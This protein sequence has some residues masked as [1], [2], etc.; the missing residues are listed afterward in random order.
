MNFNTFLLRLGFDPENFVNKES[1]PIRIYNGYI[2]EAEQR[3]DDRRCPR[4]GC[5][6]TEIH[7]HYYTETR[8]SELEYFTDILRIKRVRFR[9]PVC[10]KT[11]SPKIKGIGTKCKVSQ[12]AKAFIRND[13]TTPIT[14]DAIGGKYGVSTSYIIKMFDEEFK[15]IP[16]KPL[17]K[18]LCIDEIKFSTSNSKYCCILYDFFNKDIVDIIESRQL[19]YLKQYFEGISIKERDNVEIFISDMYDGYSTIRSLYFR[20]AIHVVDNFHVIIQLSRV[21]NSLRLE[22]MK[23]YTYKGDVFYNFMK[24]KW[25]LF[26]CR[27]ESIPDKYVAV[28]STG[29]VYHLDYLVYECIKMNPEF[30]EGYLALQDLF[31]H[32]YY[33]TFD[34][35]LR[36]VEFL[37]S[38]LKN[39]KSQLLKKVGETYYRWRVEI[40]NA[41]TRQSKSIKYTN[42]IAEC[43]NNRLKTIIKA[44]YGYRNFERFRKRALLICTYSLFRH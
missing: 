5:Q 2:Y 21:V 32:S 27:E 3:T 43:L 18:V 15:Y 42:A 22:T 38:K 14:F 35:S 9:C 36:F 37:S 11:F 39:S 30:W 29:E 13:F 40:A 7:S 28:K 4:C 41:F 34:E 16:R 1:E 25:R 12:Q 33:S 19:P 23:G 24:T 31:H 8:C 44:A 17:P 20:N 26:L 6:H 10:G